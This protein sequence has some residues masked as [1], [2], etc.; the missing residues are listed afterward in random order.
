M[1]VVETRVYGL[2]SAEQEEA[3]EGREQWRFEES[4]LDQI[5]GEVT[6]SFFQFLP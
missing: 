6:C 1:P 2:N 4:T 5:W 3:A